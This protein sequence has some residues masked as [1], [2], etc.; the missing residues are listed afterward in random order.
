M[1]S[2]NCRDLRAESI[3]T[4]IANTESKHSNPINIY[5]NYE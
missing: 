4:S 2:V 1:K 3:K 5:S